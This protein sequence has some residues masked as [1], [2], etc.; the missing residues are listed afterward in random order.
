MGKWCDHFE[1]YGS[2]DNIY[3]YIPEASPS[4]MSLWY[5]VDTCMKAIYIN[6]QSQSTSTIKNAN[7]IFVILG[8]GEL[9]TLVSQ[10]R[11]PAV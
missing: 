9:S 1:A 11:P 6:F 7:H 4:F 10:G 3:S 5:T 8:V 2:R